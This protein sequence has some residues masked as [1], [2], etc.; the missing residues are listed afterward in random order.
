MT[1]YRHADTTSRVL[2]HSALELSAEGAVEWAALHHNW[3]VFP[4]RM[5]WDEEGSSWTK[6]PLVRWTA[7]ASKDPDEIRQMWNEVGGTAVVCVACAPSNLWCLDQDRDLPEDHVGDEWRTILEAVRISRGTLVLKS[8]TRGAPHYVFRQGAEW[9]AEGVW[10]GGEVKS[11]GMIVISSHDPIVDAPVAP[12]PKS[13]LDKLKL[14]R[15]KGSYGRGACSKEELWDWLLSPPDDEDLVLDAKSSEKFL[16]AVLRQ[17]DDKIDGGAHR[18]MAVLDS[19]FQAAIEACAG[20]Y[21]AEHA[22]AAVKEAYRNHRES[23][24]DTGEKGWSR[25]RELDYSLMWQSLIPAI[26]AGDLDDKIAETRKGIL[27]RYGMWIDSDDEVEELL[28]MILDSTGAAADTGELLTEIP[29]PVSTTPDPVTNGSAPATPV[30]APEDDEFAWA[31]A[32]SPTAPGAAPELTP[33]VMHEDAWWGAHGELIEALRSRTESSDVG[34]LGALLAFSGACLA[35]RAH[36]KVGVDVHGPNDY[37]LNI[38]ASSSAR[39]SSALSLVEKGV[40]Y[41]D[42]R[43]GAPGAMFLPRRIMGMA[44]GERLIQVWTP[45]TTDDGSGGKL[46]EYPERRVMMIEG[47]ASVVWKRAAREGAVLGDTL[48]K[49]W[50]QSDVATH[51]VTSGSTSLAAER[52]L[53]GFIGCSTMHVAVAA[54]KRGDGVDAKSGFA[55]RFVWLYLPDSR[56]DLPF[57]AALPE[58]AVRRY[59]ERLGLFDGSLAGIG[60]SGF[61]IE[62][63]WSAEAREKWAAVYSDIKRDK[64]SAGFIEGM[65]SRAESHVLRMTLNYWLVS[66]GDPRAVGVQALDAALAVWRYA[67]LSTEFIFG[68]STGDKDTDNLIAELSERGGWAT[69][70]ELRFDLNRNS[71]AGLIKTGVSNGVITEGTV[72]S[73]RP[74]RPPKAVA[75]SDWIRGGR[76]SDVSQGSGRSRGISVRAVT[77]L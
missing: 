29:A 34:V 45:L 4:G 73:T 77:W 24:G 16:D 25:S 27:D 66:G 67:K 38:G 37:F 32:V 47:E 57:G 71:L 5:V 22:Y 52:H 42:D 28:G 40:F 13:L 64:G 43:L 41:A 65:L 70:D 9:V 61:G 55:N 11:S 46:T 2:T 56:I 33:P 6:K 8:C 21:P 14:G 39:K 74:G 59:Q 31:E 63:M 35:G 72:A 1:E 48:C 20:C 51:S 30:T 19:V 10:I 18:R 68:S 15:R 75:L 62:A 53:M 12:A 50:D 26:K 58:E 60:D 3:F 69:L 54:T 76:L 49:I 23:R 17:L 44:S 7:R 36:F